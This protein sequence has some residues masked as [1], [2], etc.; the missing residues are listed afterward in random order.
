MRDTQEIRVDPEFQSKIPPLS[1]DEFKRL[2]DNILDDGEVIEPICTWRGIIVDGHNRWRIIQENP[3]IP[4]KTREMIFLDK[5]E[6][7]DWMFRKQ[8]GRRNLSNEQRLRLIGQ[9]QETRKKS[10]G[11]HKGNQ[12]TDLELCQNGTIP[13]PRST[14][15]AIAREVG[16][17]ERTVNRAEKFSK[18]IDALEE[19]SK[20]AAD[21]VLRGGSGVTKATIMELPRMEPEKKEEVVKAIIEGKQKPRN[22]NKPETIDDIGLLLKEIQNAQNCVKAIGEMLM[23]KRQC[24]QDSDNRDRILEAIHV[25]KQEI[26]NLEEAI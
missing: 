4:Y 2:R 9:M 10:V 5:W 3:D 1:E 6:A 22:T 23:K 7:F 21:K 24:F 11:E 12:Y 17:S 14:A 13:N 15:E 16:V 25:V 19:I 18:G 26:K 20:E 8:L